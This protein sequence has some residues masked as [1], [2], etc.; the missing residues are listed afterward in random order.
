MEQRESR[1][2]SNDARDVVHEDRMIDRGEEAN[3]VGAKAI[4]VAAHELMCPFQ[5]RM[6]SLALPACI[7]IVKETP[8][9]ERLQDPDDSV[10][11]DPVTERRGRDQPGLRDVDVE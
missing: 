3:D 4:P 9:E 6:G 5:R 1:T 11:D 2:A 10:V 7:R 8:F